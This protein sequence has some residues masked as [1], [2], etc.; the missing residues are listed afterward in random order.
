MP[1]ER[2]VGAGG[3]VAPRP[4]P[5]GAWRPPYDFLN[6]FEKISNVKWNVETTKSLKKILNEHGK[7]IN[8]RPLY[9]TVLKLY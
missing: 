9:S 4:G 5:T 3:T 8:K 2:G 7:D 6:K 1:V